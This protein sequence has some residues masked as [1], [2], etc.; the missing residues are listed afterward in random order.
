VVDAKH[1][2]FRQ[3]VDYWNSRRGGHKMPAASDIDTLE[4]PDLLPYLSLIDI[5][6]TPRRFRYRVI[7]TGVVDYVGRDLTG[8]IVDDSVF[9]SAALQVIQFFERVAAG[10]P[11]IASWTATYPRHAGRFETIGLPLGRSH[12]IADALLTLTHIVRP[13]DRELQQMEPAGEPGNPFRSFQIRP[14]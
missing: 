8:C 10:E 1:P 4:I 2:Y 3:V 11:A 7:G 6:E 14:L 9:G 5:I 13:A 12:A